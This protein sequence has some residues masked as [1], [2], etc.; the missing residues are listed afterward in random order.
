[1]T[2]WC[3]VMLL[4]LL[5]Y[6]I[7]VIMLWVLLCYVIGVIMFVLGVIHLTTPELTCTCS[8]VQRFLN[9]RGQIPF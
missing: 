1:M 3:P 4:V 5:C 7:G 8:G 2:I 9:A 6:V